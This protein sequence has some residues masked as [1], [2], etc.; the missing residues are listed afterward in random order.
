MFLPL[1]YAVSNQHAHF[2]HPMSANVSRTDLQQVLEERHGHMASPLSSKLATLSSRRYVVF[3]DDI[4]LSQ[5]A[6]PQYSCNELLRQVLSTGHVYEPDRYIPSQLSG[7]VLVASLNSLFLPK[8]SPRFLRQWF[9][10]NVASLPDTGVR[11]TVSPWIMSWLEEF[12][13]YSVGNLAAVSEVRY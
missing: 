12:P 5:A 6:H 8:T 11:C 7:L 4:H 2:R 9:T 10:V 1:Q 3:L 13:A